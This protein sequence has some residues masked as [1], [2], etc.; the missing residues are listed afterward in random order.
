MKKIEI[1]G[2]GVDYERYAMNLLFKKFVNDYK[3]NSVLELPAKGEK[4][5]PSIYSL[6]F[7]QHGCDVTLVNHE[8][9]SE[10]AWEKLGYDVKYQNEKNLSKTSLKDNS[11]DLVW[12]FMFLSQFEDKDSLIN[13]MIRLSKKYVFFVAVNRFNVGFFSH[14]AVHK[15]FREPWTHGDVNYMNPFYVKKIFEKNNLKIKDI[16]IVDAPPWPDSLGIR[17]MKLHRKKV[18]LTKIDWDSRT[19]NWMKEEKY[20]NKF[21]FYYAIENLPLPWILKL[22]YAHLFYVI[23]EKEYV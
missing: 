19:I 8:K 12:N 15:I 17:D 16:G 3:I 14:R 21:R 20:P 13:E 11:F 10:W 7:A 22:P 23:G 4:A 18:D 9:K 5:M 6:N 2:S 1:E